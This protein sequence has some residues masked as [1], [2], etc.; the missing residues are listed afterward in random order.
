MGLDPAPLTLSRGLRVNSNSR[1]ALV[2][3]GGKSTA[4]FLLAG[5]Q[6][7]IGMVTTT[8]HLSEQQIGRADFVH[9]LASLADV[10]DA[11][12]LDSGIHLFLGPR[13]LLNDRY[14]GPEPE[15]LMGLDQLA[16]AL[17]V[18]L[19]IEADGARRRPLK[20]PVDH[21]PALPPFINSVAV[22][23][24][25]T[26][27][28]QPVQ[29]V[30]RPTR[31]A[32]LAGLHPDGLVESNHLVRVLLSEAGGLKGVPPTAAKA[33]I[34]NQADTPALEAQASEMAPA[35]L[36]SY[37]RVLTARLESG[38][39]LAAVEPQALILLAAGGSRRLGRSKQ[40]L[41]W[42]GRPLVRHIAETALASQVGELIVVTGAVEQE[43]HGALSGLTYLPAHNPEWSAG[44]STSVQVG[45]NALTD[46]VGAA[47]FLLV[48]Q[49]WVNSGMIKALSELHSRTLAPIVAPL[50]DQQRGNPVLFD[51]STFIDFAELSGDQGARPLFAKHRAQW[52]PWHDD[53]ALLDIDS[54]ADYAQLIELSSLGPEHQH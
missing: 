52:L 34:F 54:E 30:H 13:K 11:D 5:E 35:L 8:T 6:P 48:D 44:Q 12:Q 7:V 19:F 28:D 15:V 4:L 37:D 3:A 21:E 18:P 16:T 47:I 9:F 40:L 53:R 23:A 24:G 22:L 39:I 46:R 14:A 10:P 36:V 29:A 41:D 20:A 27:I 50:I 1:L 26:G 33:V 45:I 2:G 17:N 38:R 32:A 49:P 51:R 25:L 43:I 31:F 42:Q